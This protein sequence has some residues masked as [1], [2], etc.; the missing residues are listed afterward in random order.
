MRL[1]GLKTAAVLGGGALGL[2]WAHA[3]LEH[4]V[5]VTLIERAPRFL[6][7]ALDEVASDLLAT[8]LRK[9]GIDVLFNDEVRAVHP[10]PRGVAGVALASGRGVAC[11]LVAAALGV[12]PNT[13]FLANT[14]IQLAKNGAVA[15]D[16]RL[17]SSLPGVWPRAMW[18]AS[19]A[20]GSRSG[21]P[22]ACRPGL[23]PKTC[24]AA[25]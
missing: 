18:P 20:S 16:S 9:A 13:E 24:A 6:P 10:G 12:V 23:R 3:L 5:K 8:R 25:R 1:R 15:V 11:E 19:R 4:G 22:R 2:E 17:Q 21:N 14:G 7:G